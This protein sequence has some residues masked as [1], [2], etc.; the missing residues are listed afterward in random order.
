MWVF[1]LRTRGRVCTV[2]GRETAGSDLPFQKFTLAVGGRRDEGGPGRW[3]R[4]A[5]RTLPFPRRR[6]RSLHRA[7]TGETGEQTGEQAD[8]LRG[9]R[10][11]KRSSLEALSTARSTLHLIFQMGFYF[12]CFSA[13]C[14][15]T[16]HPLPPPPRP[17]YFGAELPEFA[18]HLSQRLGSEVRQV[19]SGQ[20][21]TPSEPPCPEALSSSGEDDLAGF[22]R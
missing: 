9:K 5:G 15:P 18:S 4:P 11:K 16:F 20:L 13:S 22:W 10:W 1:N 12:L 7:S 2:S 6:T 21:S 19:S 14:A 17:R 3:E 8:W